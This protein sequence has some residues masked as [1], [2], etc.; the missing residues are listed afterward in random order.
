VYIKNAEPWSINKCVLEND[1]DIMLFHWVSK[2]WC[3]KSNI[4]INS[5]AD[6]QLCANN[7]FWMRPILSLMGK[8]T[9]IKN[10]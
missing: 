2:I 3:E 6:E 8:F 5:K 1:W 10:K 7:K 9:G 4:Y